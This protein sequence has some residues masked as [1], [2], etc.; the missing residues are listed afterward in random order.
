M[1]V[2]IVGAGLGTRVRNITF[3]II[4]KF[5]IQIDTFNGLYYILEY[6]KQYAEHIYFV[7]HPKYETITHYYIQ[8]FHPNLSITLVPFAE[9][10]GTA[11]TIKDTIEKYKDAICDKPLFVTWF[12]IYPEQKERIRFESFENEDVTVLLYGNECRYFYDTHTNDIYNLGK[13]GGNVI[14]MYYFMF[15]EQ[16]LHLPIEKGYDIVDYLNIMKQKLFIFVIK[17]SILRPFTIAILI[18]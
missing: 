18:K 2:M 10:V 3:E 15:P 11:Y 5:L 8:Q 13:T 9:S 16:I 17:N 4:P 12:D 7:I 14:G 1:N 6:W